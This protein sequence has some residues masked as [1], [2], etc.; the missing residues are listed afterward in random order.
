LIRVPVVE[1][2]EGVKPSVRRQFCGPI[3]AAAPGSSQCHGRLRV[4][5]QIYGRYSFE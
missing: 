5:Q 3:G 2:Y 4:A 1:H